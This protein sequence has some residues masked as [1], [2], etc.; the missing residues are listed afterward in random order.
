M[1]DAFDK[2]VDIKNLNDSD[3]YLNLINTQ[4][5]FSFGTITARDYLE[6]KNQDCFEN[7][8]EPGKHPNSLGYNLISKELYNYIVDNNII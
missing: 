3:N 4:K 5:Y 2:M 1:I 8:K 7:T 6:S